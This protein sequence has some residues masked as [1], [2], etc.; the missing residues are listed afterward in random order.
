METAVISG[1]PTYQLDR[2]AAFSNFSVNVPT[3]GNSLADDIRCPSMIYS[4][5]VRI[6]FANLAVVALCSQLAF[7][8]EPS[9]T[10]LKLP[11]TFRDG[12]NLPIHN[13]SVADLEAKVHGKTVKFLSLAPDQ[14]AHRLVLI[15]DTSGSMGSIAGEAP[16]WKLELS[17]AR[18]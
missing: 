11:V 1:H 17:L 18:H 8:D 2:C 14:R 15:L 3:C 13:I 4:G 16:P 5:Y 12:Q 10:I 7:S 6:S 9:C